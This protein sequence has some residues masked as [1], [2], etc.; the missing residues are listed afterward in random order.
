VSGA[1]IGF[2]IPEYE[3]KK[4]EG[5]VTAGGILLS[6]HT[7]DAQT[8]SRAKKILERTGAKDIATTSEVK[9]SSAESLPFKRTDKNQDIPSITAY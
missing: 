4:Y 1:L 2:G 8:A 5:F 6:V 7:D 9:N 3:A